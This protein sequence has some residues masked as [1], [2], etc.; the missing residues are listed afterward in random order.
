MR[1]I[2]AKDLLMVGNG[3]ATNMCAAVHEANVLSLH[4]VYRMICWVNWRGKL[5]ASSKSCKKQGDSLCCVTY[6]FTW[7]KWNL[8]LKQNFEATCTSV[9][10]YTAELYVARY[11]LL[12]SNSCRL[13]LEEEGE[14]VAHLEPENH[15][16]MK[17]CRR[18]QKV[19][20]H[21]T[22]HCDGDVGF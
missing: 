3:P 4:L 2:R 9:G 10:T 16:L 21:A 15:K 11:I 6:L 20:E 13:K 22:A 1:A 7:M 18:L 12:T 8:L 17:E 19:P 14:K 5:P